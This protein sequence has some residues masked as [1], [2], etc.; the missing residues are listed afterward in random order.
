MATQQRW[1]PLESNPD[2]FNDWAKQ[3]G[4]IEAD[5]HFQD[6]YGLDDDLL[7]FV[8]RPVKAVILLFPDWKDGKQQRKEEDE[9]IAKEGQPKLDKTIL[10]IKQ[11][12]DNACGTMA[13][14][15]ALANSN[16][17]IAPMSP[18]AKFIDQCRDITPLERAKL[19]ETT[20]LFSEIHAKQASS[21]QTAVPTDLNTNLH[22]TCFVEAP[23][24]GYRGQAGTTQRVE[25]G[26]EPEGYTYMRLIELDGERQGPV[27]RGECKDLLKDVAKIV[28]EKYIGESSSIEFNLIALG[29]PQTSG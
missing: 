19:L 18:L 10:W 22:F 6:V 26:K 2:V 24:E 16:V 5:A 17:T 27:D 28:K 23:D 3:A 14:I 20:S 4:L 29:G 13:L 21:G 8:V 25:G 9:K 7:S 1:I 12:I 11:T 15:H